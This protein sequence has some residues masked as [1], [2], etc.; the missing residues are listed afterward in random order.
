MLSLPKITTT[1]KLR[2]RLTEQLGEAVRLATINLSAGQTV[3]ASLH[4]LAMQLANP[5]G[6]EIECILARRQAGVSM[7]LALVDLQKKA[8]SHDIDLFCDALILAEKGGGSILPLFEMLGRS[9]DESKALN[10]KISAVTAQGK[11]QGIVLAVLP[12]VVLFAVHWV[13]PH[14][15]T[16]LISTTLGKTVLCLC[17]LSNTVGLIWICKLTRPCL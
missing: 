12:V 2:R 4:E 7:E 6:Q 1:R 16:P 5:L 11:L 3:Q 10:E 9:L 8:M 13:A 17:A 14:Y 15:L